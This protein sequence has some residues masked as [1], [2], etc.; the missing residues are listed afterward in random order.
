MGRL[1]WSH[2]GLHDN[3]D[4]QLG[5]DLRDRSGQYTLIGG[6]EIEVAHFGKPSFCLCKLWP[7]HDFA[8]LHYFMPPGATCII[9]IL[10]V[11]ASVPR[12]VATNAADNVGLKNTPH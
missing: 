12:Y 9:C 4:V 6:N 8:V 10:L 5:P 3:L 7:M 11:P 2:K 1:P